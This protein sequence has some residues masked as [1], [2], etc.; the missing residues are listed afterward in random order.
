[1]KKTILLLFLFSLIISSCSRDDS[2]EATTNSATIK[3]DNTSWSG[4]FNRADI[5]VMTNNSFDI[6]IGKEEKVNVTFSENSKF[7][8]RGYIKNNAEWVYNSGPYE[9]SFV[10]NNSG[11]IT[12]NYES[13]ATF[14]LLNSGSISG[15]E[16]TLKVGNTQ[17]KFIK[18]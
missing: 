15:N 5:L 13:G 4:L 6:G 7:K 1:M 12:L 8:L 17:Y 16:M 3:L 10:V 11:A 14:N 9:G 18:D 2:S